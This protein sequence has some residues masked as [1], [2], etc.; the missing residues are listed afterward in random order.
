MTS[1]QYYE[2]QV[3]SLRSE[4]PLP[5]TE[6][7]SFLKTLLAKPVDNFFV[8]ERP[9]RPAIWQAEDIAS[10]EIYLQGQETDIHD[11]EVEWYDQWDEV[12]INYLMAATPQEFIVPCIDLCG[13]LK[14]KYS[15]QLFYEDVAIE[16]NDLRQKLET[17]ALELT[18]NYDE[19]GSHTL[20]ALV[21][22]EY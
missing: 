9:D 5:Q 11:E 10:I 17:I 22:M 20:V 16:L 19:P 13:K 2:K 4:E 12:R 21:A 3:M 8:L 1:D 15:L 6:L 18:E 7:R 14:D